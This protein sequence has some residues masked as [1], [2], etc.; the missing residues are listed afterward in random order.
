MLY[1]IVF[2]F[3]AYC[4]VNIQEKPRFLMGAKIEQIRYCHIRRDRIE[5]F[6]MKKTTALFLL[7]LGLALAFFACDDKPPPQPHENTITVSRGTATVKGDPSIPTADFNTAFLNLKAG[8]ESIDT[9]GGTSGEMARFTNMLNRGITIVVGNAVPASVGGAL[10]VGVDYLKTSDAHTIL[11]AVLDL[12]VDANA[13]AN[14]TIIDN[15]NGLAFD[16]KV[17]IKGNAPMPVTVFA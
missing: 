6:F 4:L 2:V 12:I 3:F 1:W 13:F 17:T 5:E 11:I 14:L 15:T 7:L 8:L 16:G 9:E 10:T